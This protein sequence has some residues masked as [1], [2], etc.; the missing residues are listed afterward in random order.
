[1]AGFLQD[2]TG[3]NSMMRLACMAIVSVLLFDITWIVV[4]TATFPEH[5]WQ[6]FV[7]IVGSLWMKE[8]QLG[9]EDKKD[10]C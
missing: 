10:S 8:R 9:K 5:G 4:K 2:S 3:N 6:A 1:M 7:G